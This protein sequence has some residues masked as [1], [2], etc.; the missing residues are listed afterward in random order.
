[1]RSFK[2][3]FSPEFL[4]SYQAG[5]LFY[6]YRDIPCLKNPI[7][8]AI[9]LQVLWREKPKTLIEIGS[10]HGG[11]AVFF[12]DMCKIYEFDTQIISIDLNPPPIERSNVIFRQGDV[13]KLEDAFSPDEL[14]TM[15]RP[16]LVIE[17][18][19]HTFT[20]CWATLD[21]FAKHL[22]CGELLIMEDGVLDELGLSERYDG[23]PNRAI[24]E[25]DAAHPDIFSIDTHY[26][27]MFGV[28]ATYNPNGY[29]RRSDQ[30]LD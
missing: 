5:H 28:N 11:S 6:Q 19:A 9:Y 30:I 27:D 18:S 24:S 15:P 20:G 12:S 16:W 8:L 22:R 2:T 29:L 26:T 21:F 7:D 13:C 25:F 23:G 10:K 1:M 17:D 14:N 4:K 3:L